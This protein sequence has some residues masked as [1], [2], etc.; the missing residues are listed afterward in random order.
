MPKEA[1]VTHLIDR[2]DNT[3]PGAGAK[4]V[5]YGKQCNYE[6]FFS[7]GLRLAAKDIV[8]DQSTGFTKYIGAMV[9]WNGKTFV[10]DS[11]LIDGNTAIAFPIDPES[12]NEVISN[13]EI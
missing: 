8:K 11:V 10:Y 6:I 1:K 7:G 2:W 9:D 13:K 5:Q 12:I 4:V 3:D